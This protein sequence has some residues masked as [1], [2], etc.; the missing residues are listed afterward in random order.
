MRKKRRPALRWGGM[1]GGAAA[2]LVLIHEVLADA[3]MDAT[4]ANTILA[5]AVFLILYLGL[6]FAAGALAAHQTG[7]VGAGTAAGL[8]AGAITGGAVLL[9]GLYV[10]LIHTPLSNP[11]A[12]AP[13]TP[14]QYH[15][16]IILRALILFLALALVLAGCGAGFG[17]L[18]GV[19]G[20]P[21]SSAQ[22]V[23]M[24]SGEES[25]LP[26]VAPLDAETI[27][28]VLATETTETTE[29]AEAAA[30]AVIETGTEI[31]APAP[32]AD[33]DAAIATEP[34]PVINSSHIAIGEP[35][36]ERE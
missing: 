6:F 3:V 19:A 32:P 13:L 24:P 36:V 35:P 34:E 30:V 15:L 10:N 2:A 28:A 9:V 29:V 18:G 20:R 25:A 1:F 5:G 12:Q 33:S 27:P 17:A 22:V 4:I 8:I 26:A 21:V 23:S 11:P 16:D 7:S 31:A 14:F